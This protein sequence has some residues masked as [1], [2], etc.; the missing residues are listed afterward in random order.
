MRNYTLLVLGKKANLI[1]QVKKK[2]RR[3]PVAQRFYAEE[4]ACTQECT[5]ILL[6]YINLSCANFFT[7]DGSSEVFSNANKRPL[8]VLGW[9]VKSEDHQ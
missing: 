9:L 7:D 1:W 4:A 3:P 8:N 6:V 2:I 5:C